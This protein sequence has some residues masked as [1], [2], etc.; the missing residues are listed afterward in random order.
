MNHNPNYVYAE[1]L[2]LPHTTRSLVIDIYAG[3]ENVIAKDEINREI[4]ERHFNLRG[5]SAL[6]DDRNRYVSRS[7]RELPNAY[8]RGRG[9]GLSYWKIDHLE[10]GTGNKW[11][12][13]FYFE[14]DQYKAMRDKKWC[15]KCNIGRTSNDPFNRIRDQTSGAP[16]APIIPLLIRTDDEKAL[17]TYIHSIL[18]ARSRHLTNTNTN[19]DFLTCPSEVARIVFDSPHFNGKKIA[20]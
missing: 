2:L 14:P 3:K 15:W 11:V 4:E 18:K 8:H 13:C 1:A 12:Y 9:R 16:K 10:L 5:E 17:E 6:R 19:E 7:L 20:L